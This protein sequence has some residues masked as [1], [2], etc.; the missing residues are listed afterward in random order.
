M[1][2]CLFEYDIILSKY[3]N[4]NFTLRLIYI[5]K[6]IVCTTV[7]CL[8]TDEIFLRVNNAFVIFDRLFRSLFFVTT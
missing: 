2:R 6:V 3:V 8:V 5:L 7:D 1:Q 4:I